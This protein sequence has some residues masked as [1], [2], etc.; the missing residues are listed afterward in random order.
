MYIYIFIVLYSFS[1]FNSL[2]LCVY[3]DFFSLIYSFFIYQSCFFVY[4]Q[5]FIVLFYSLVRWRRAKTFTL[6]L[7]P[8]C[9]HLQLWNFICGCTFMISTRHTHFGVTRSKVMVT[10]KLS[11]IQKCTR[12]WALAP[13]MWC[14][15]LDLSSLVLYVYSGL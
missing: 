10:D 7:K 1:D 15:C 2:V 8:K 4:I 3:S 11:F 9:F 13:L 5:M 14:S 12:S 6:A